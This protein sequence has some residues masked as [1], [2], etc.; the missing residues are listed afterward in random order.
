M[1]IKFVIVLYSNQPI[2][3]RE[4]SLGA[5]NFWGSSTEVVLVVA[6]VVLVEEVVLVAAIVLVA[7]EEVVVAE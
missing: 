7:V 5:K 3:G 1:E 4:M 6:L 2:S